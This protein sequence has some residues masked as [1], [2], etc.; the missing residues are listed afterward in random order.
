MNKF[1]KLIVLLLVVAVGSLGLIGCKDKADHP[2]GNDH[3]STETAT[4]ENPAPDH[5][6]GEHPK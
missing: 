2:T 5:P 3:P 6:K 4:E 1:K